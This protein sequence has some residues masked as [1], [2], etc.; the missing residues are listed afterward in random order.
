METILSG[1]IVLCMFY[2]GGMIEHTYIQDQKMSSCLKAK[3]TVERSVNPQN[4][5]MTCGKFKAVI[6]NDNGRM[7]VIKIIEAKK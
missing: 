2:Q 4:V 5:R 7:R 1:V 3:R 6:E